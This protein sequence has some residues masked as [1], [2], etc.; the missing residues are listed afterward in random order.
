V[1]DLKLDFLIPEGTMGSSIFLNG[2]DAFKILLDCGVIHY[3]NEIIVPQIPAGINQI[4]I[5]H[6]HLDHCAALPFILKYGEPEIF[7]TPPTLSFI[8]YLLLDMWNLIKRCDLKCNMKLTDDDMQHFLR[9][10]H[11]MKRPIEPYQSVNIENSLRFQYIPAGHILG[12][13]GMNLWLN[14]KSIVYT[15]DICTYNTNYLVPAARDYFIRNPDILISEATYGNKTEHIDSFST[16]NINLL[17]IIKQ[18]IQ[19]DAPTIIPAYALQRVEEVYVRLAREMHEGRIPKTPIYT[20]GRLAT[21]V[22]R[23]FR[24]FTVPEYNVNPDLAMRVTQSDTLVDIFDDTFITSLNKTSI[25]DKLQTINEGSGIFI[26]PAGSLQGGYSPLYLKEVAGNPKAHLILVGHQFPDTLGE[27]IQQ[28]KKTVALPGFDGR[29][30]ETNLECQVH[31]FHLSAHAHTGQLIDLVKFLNPKTVFFQHGTQRSI[32]TMVSIRYG[33]DIIAFRPRETEI[34]MDDTSATGLNV[35]Y[36][37]Q[38]QEALRLLS[39][40]LADIFNKLLKDIDLT[41]IAKAD[42]DNLVERTLEYQKDRERA[43]FR[44]SMQ[45]VGSYVQSSKGNRPTSDPEWRR[46]RGSH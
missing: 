28:G 42:V 18:S 17:N 1:N 37:Q 24:K 6:G 34:A 10:F 9:V 46:G 26:V 15:G 27:R 11:K 12:A 44:K 8:E 35:L 5:S 40:R 20:D 3:G 29:I 39:P 23:V 2:G 30:D 7:G 22:L 43:K 36:L 13:C 4:F 16:A 38:R 41:T 33:M 32:N 31:T 25:L 45:R 19:D 21:N 14:D